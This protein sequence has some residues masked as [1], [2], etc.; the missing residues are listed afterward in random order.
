MNPPELP[1]N[2]GAEASPLN[3]DAETGLPHRPRVLVVVNSTGSPV[4]RLEPWL[5]AE[6]LDLD[7][8]LG[9]EDPLPE[10]LDGYAGLVMLGGGLMPDEDDR[11]PWLPAERALASQAIDADLPTLGVCL[12]GQI[13]AHVGGGE[14]RA[15]FGASEYGHTAIEILDAGSTDPLAQALAPVTM[16]VEHH[17]DRITRLPE[18]A[19]WLAR[20]EACENQM[21]RLGHNVY[22]VQFH[23]ETGVEHVRRW[24]ADEL[25][26]HGQSYDEIVARA[27]Q[28]EEASTLACRAFAGA[29]AARVRGEGAS[30]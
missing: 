25:A 20:S 11:A 2:G 4:R 12:G 7:L 27:E 6:G 26:E 18:G 19:A 1:A 5:L 17:Q 23:P 30:A 16:I 22:G 14:V 29:F 10:T 8:R 15:K 13:L 24:N 9:A 21:F 3:T 28:S